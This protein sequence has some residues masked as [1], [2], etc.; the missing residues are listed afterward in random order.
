MDDII[1]KILQ[2]DETARKMEDEAQ[3]EKIASREEV[4]QKRQEVYDEYLK[5]AKTHV[6]EYK[7][8][9]SKIAEEKM[10]ETEKRYRGISKALEKKYNDNK[11]KWVNGIVNGV[12]TY[13]N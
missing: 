10:K 7:K 4:K 12:L 13:N 9:E 5:S 3:A 8:S 2:M 1:S 11:E 6:E